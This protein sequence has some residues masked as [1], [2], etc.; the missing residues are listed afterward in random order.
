MRTFLHDDAGN[1][2]YDNRAGGGY[3]YA[4]DAAGRME[5]FSINGVVQATYRYDAMGQQ[6]VRHLVQ[7]G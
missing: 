3:G 4:Y 5:A 2:L 7:D 6:V 1:V